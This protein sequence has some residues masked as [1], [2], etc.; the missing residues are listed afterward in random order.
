MALGGW[1]GGI[2]FD[3]TGSYNIALILSVAASLGGMLSIALLESPNK[4][5]IPDWEKVGERKLTF[6]V[7]SD[8]VKPGHP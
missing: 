7:S 3:T 2:I 4:L 6:P 5:L 1:I 8:S